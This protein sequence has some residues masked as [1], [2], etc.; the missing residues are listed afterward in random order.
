M[1]SC[2]QSFFPVLL[3]AT[4][5][6]KVRFLQEAAIMGQFRHPNIVRLYGVVT[7]HEPV[8]IVLELMKKGDLKNYVKSLRPV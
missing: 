5:Q 6:D 4:E 1:F 2:P 3:Q 7:V 8:M